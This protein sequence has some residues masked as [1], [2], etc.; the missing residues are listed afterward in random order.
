MRGLR[1]ASEALTPAAGHKSQAQDWGLIVFC[2]DGAL[3]GVQVPWLVP[4]FLAR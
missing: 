3:S 2:S 4:T 1:A